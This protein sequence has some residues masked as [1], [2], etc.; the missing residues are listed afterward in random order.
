MDV[1]GCLACDLTAGRRELPG[2]LICAAEGWR[3]EHCVGP[4]GVGTLLLKPERHVTR[5]AGLTPQEAA[6]QGTLIHRCCSLIE[7]LLSPAQTYVCLW[8]HAGGKPAH[9]HYVIQPVSDAQ[10]AAGAL[11]PTL[12]AQMFSEGAQP[13]REQVE[14]FA[15]RARSE[16]DQTRRG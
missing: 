9:I 6:A 4:L 3:I 1:V 13:D 7:T 10:V 11:G 12:Q 2:G 8:S 15:D 14:R 16:L 5:I